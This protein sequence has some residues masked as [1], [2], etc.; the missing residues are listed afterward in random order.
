MNNDKEIVVSANCIYCHNSQMVAYYPAISHK[1]GNIRKFKALRGQCCVY[2]EH[3]ISWVDYPEG[4]AQAIEAE[5][6]PVMAVAPAP[7]VP[8]GIR[9]DNWPGVGQPIIKVDKKK[10]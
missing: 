3:S 9:V 8:D 5:H 7:V 4:E 2:C 6:L 1:V 10:A